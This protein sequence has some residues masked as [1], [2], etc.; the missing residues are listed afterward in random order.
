LPEFH[1]N[2]WFEKLCNGFCPKCRVDNVQA[3]QVF[4]VSE[5][6]ELQEKL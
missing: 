5:E 2:E 1:T 4:F 3:F 6:N